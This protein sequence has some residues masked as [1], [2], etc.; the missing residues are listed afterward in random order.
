MKK[1]FLILALLFMTSTI[2]SAPRILTHEQ[3]I[4][5]TKSLIEARITAQ[6][7]ETL[8]KSNLLNI[9]TQTKLQ[10]LEIFIKRPFNYRLTNFDG[11]NFYVE[12][13]K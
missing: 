12:E 9:D 6:E 11:T 8:Q 2:K 5:I 10:L 7:I 3:A 13:V 1:Y 4:I